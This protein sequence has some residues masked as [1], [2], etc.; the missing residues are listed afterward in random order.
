MGETKCVEMAMPK[1]WFL[2]Y[3]LINCHLL[4]ETFDEL[5]C[6]IESCYE[7]G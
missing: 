3:F 6:F 1:T 5:C 4:S 2:K 7:E